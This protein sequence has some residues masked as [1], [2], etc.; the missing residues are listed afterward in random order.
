MDEQVPDYRIYFAAERTFLAWIRT[1]LTVIGLGFVV[2]RFGLFLRVLRER[3]AA[4]S[5]SIPS[6][7]IGVLLV[8]LGSAAVIMATLQHLHYYRSLPPASRPRTTSQIWPVLFALL[9]AVIGL[10]LAAYLVGKADGR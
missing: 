2:S 4:Q 8:L 5:A 6:T 3:D 9:L 1:G 10:F 7:V